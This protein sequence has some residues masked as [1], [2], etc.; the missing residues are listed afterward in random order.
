[1]LGNQPSGQGQ[2]RHAAEKQQVEQQQ[3]LVDPLYEPE[4]RVV[5]RPDDSDLKEG[6]PRRR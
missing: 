2:Q 4:Q 3:Q 1:V 6:S 5:V